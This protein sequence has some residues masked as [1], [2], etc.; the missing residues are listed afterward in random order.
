MYPMLINRAPVL[1]L[2]ATIV[3]QRMGYNED[4]ALSLGK[5]VAGYTAQSKGRTL[6]IYTAREKG[7]EREGKGEGQEVQIVELM[8][9]HIPISEEGAEIRALTKDKPID[10]DSVR[11]YLQKKFGEN[12]GEVSAAMETLAGSYEPQELNR[13]A[14]QFY[15]KFRPDIPRGKRGW[16]AKGELNM[17]KITDLMV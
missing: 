2:W 14:F 10:P 13:I 1:T 17:Q 15:E 3:A 11:R 5:A 16:G 7:K 12:L 8:G 6:G 9:R 4:E